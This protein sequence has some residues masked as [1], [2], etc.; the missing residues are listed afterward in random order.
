MAPPELPVVS[1][2][3]GSFSVHQEGVLVARFSDEKSARDLAIRLGWEG[4]IELQRDGVVIWHNRKSGWAK[5]FHRIANKI[6]PA[7]G[8]WRT[9]YEIHQNGLVVATVN[10]LANALIEADRLAARGEAPTVIEVRSR[11]LSRT[12]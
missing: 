9:R 5:I 8:A 2:D 4:P 10:R 11:V 3:S 12:N 1:S 7:H 6:A